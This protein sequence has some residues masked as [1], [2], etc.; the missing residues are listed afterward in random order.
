MRHDNLWYR[1]EDKAYYYVSNDDTCDICDNKLVVD[2]V[3]VREVG[4][5]F[6]RLHIFCKSCASKTENDK[7]VLYDEKN[8]AIITSFIPPNSILVLRERI[9]L[10]S[11]KDFDASFTNRNIS[12]FDIK[13]IDKM[14][15]VTVDKTVYAGRES[16][17]G[18]SIGRDDIIAELE[19]KDKKSLSVDEGLAFLD[20]IAS[21]KLVI[22]GEE[23]K[24]LE[25]DKNVV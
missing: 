5:N 6:D 8:Y 15:G 22:E 14:G 21:A 2:C 24:R 25:G 4:K 18:A 19:Q 13:E 23:V 3:W 10:K 11:T 12:N 20:S 17:E 1:A 16:W 9:S 7:L